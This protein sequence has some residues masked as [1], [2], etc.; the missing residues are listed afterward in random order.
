MYL[1][2]KRIWIASLL[3]IL[4]YSACTPDYVYKIVPISRFGKNVVQLPGAQRIPPNIMELYTVDSFLTDAECS[5]LIDI[6]EKHLSPSRIMGQSTEPDKYRN[7]TIRT[8]H[9]AYLGGL[10]DAD[11]ASFTDAIA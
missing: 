3:A 4:L 2:R 8:S 5:R 10:T 6:I 1:P 7:Q 9:T 11:E